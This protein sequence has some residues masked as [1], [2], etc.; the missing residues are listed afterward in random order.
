MLGRNQAGTASR[1]YGYESKCCTETLVCK[2]I[3]IFFDQ[4]GNI[5][6]NTS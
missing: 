5:M 1:E 6:V 2:S 3:L 4:Y